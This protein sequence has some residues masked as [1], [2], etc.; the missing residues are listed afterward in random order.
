ME[1]DG[2][3]GELGWR[4]IRGAGGDCAG[5]DGCEL[6][7]SIGEQLKV[8]WMD[9]LDLVDVT[10][11]WSFE[12]GQLTHTWLQIANMRILLAISA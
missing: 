8:A 5:Y 10:R 7:E 1:Y 12:V 4:E 3:G 2:A 6:V 9:Q 11:L